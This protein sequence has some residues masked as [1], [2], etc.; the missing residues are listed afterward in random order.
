MVW[1]RIADLVYYKHVEGDVLQS[2]KN[3]EIEMVKTDISVRCSKTI[4]NALCITGT[5]AA[6]FTFGASL[7]ATGAGIGIYVASTL[8]ESA[9][10]SFY[11]EKAKEE[12]EKYSDIAEKLKSWTIDTQE[13]VVTVYKAVIDATFLYLIY[14]KISKATLEMVKCIPEN[15]F[16]D[17]LLRLQSQFKSFVINLTSMISTNVIGT[18]SKVCAKQIS[19]EVS[20]SIAKLASKKGLFAVMSL[21]I[22]VDV[23]DIF[24]IWKKDRPEAIKQVQDAIKQ[25][26]ENSQCPTSY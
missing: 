14:S 7:I 1:D 15:K 25:L 17:I 10:L 4:A 5:L 12:L 23:V 18:T 20:E 13:V 26:E 22:I 19:S 8:G 21:A 2:L 11:I 6:P 3:L 24:R 9:L 16:L